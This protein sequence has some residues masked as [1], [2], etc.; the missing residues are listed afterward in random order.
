MNSLEFL[1]RMR[2][3]QL[4]WSGEDSAADGR[5]PR[6]HRSPA[7]DGCVCEVQNQ[8]CNESMHCNLHHTDIEDENWLSHSDSTDPSDGSSEKKSSRRLDGAF[9]SMA[10]LIANVAVGFDVRLAISKCS[11]PNVARKA[12]NDPWK[13]PSV[14][15]SSS[16]RSTFSGRLPYVPP[17]ALINPPPFINKRMHP[18]STQHQP[19]HYSATRQRKR[20]SVN[21]DLPIK[22]TESGYESSF[23][24]T[25][26]S[27]RR[28][29][30][31]HSAGSPARCSPTTLRK[32]SLDNHEELVLIS[33]SPSKEF[34]KQQKQMSTSSDT[35]SIFETATNTPGNY[36][37]HSQE[38]DDDNF[39]SKFTSPS[40]NSNC[41]AS[42][43]SSAASFDSAPRDFSKC[44][45]GVPLATINPPPPRRSSSQ[46]RRLQQPER[47]VTLDIIPRPRPHAGLLKRTSPVHYMHYSGSP[48]CSNL[49]VTI[50]GSY[51]LRNTFK[52]SDHLHITI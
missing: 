24:W 11:T 3:R 38:T 40:R 46:E 37:G 33:L 45:S 52:W 35:G 18:A 14:A 47:P 49:C 42:S 10:A 29:T 22:F 30:P 1:L 2:T 25:P 15:P 8:K 19:G 13:P 50:K 20:S 27:D 5:R 39:S 23:V 48:R 4:P 16:S 6:Q 43:I 34:V 31:S 51:H 28:P 9:L 26:S 36:S 12:S 21:F 7:G 17:D 44:N 32:G 41:M